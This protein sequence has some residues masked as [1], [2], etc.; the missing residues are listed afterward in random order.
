MRPTLMGVA[1]T[2]GADAV[3]SSPRAAAPVEALPGDAA[4]DVPGPLGDLPPDTTPLPPADVAEPVLPA[5]PVSDGRSRPRSLPAL[6][7][8]P[9]WTPVLCGCWPDTREPH[10]VSARAT[11]TST[12]R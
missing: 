6:A 2:P 7:P 3:S 8:A 4:A 11:T 1:V 5:A 10:A 12:D 9:V